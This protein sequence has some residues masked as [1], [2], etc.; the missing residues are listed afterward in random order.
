MD[1]VLARIL[2]DRHNKL[3]SRSTYEM[4]NAAF[5]GQINPWDLREELNKTWMHKGEAI[6]I[7]RNE[8]VTSSLLFYIGII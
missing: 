6:I 8:I 4:L 1:D 2:N 7:I 3:G 5:P